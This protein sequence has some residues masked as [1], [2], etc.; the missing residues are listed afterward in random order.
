MSDCNFSFSGCTYEGLVYTE[1]QQVAISEEPCLNCSCRQG[2]L[3][4][5]LR[6]CRPLPNPPPPDCVLI[7]RNHHCCPELICRGEW[8]YQTQFYPSKLKFKIHFTL[9]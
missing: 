9:I 3:V 1:G 8:P 6:V 7:Q 2:S 4:C 5:Y